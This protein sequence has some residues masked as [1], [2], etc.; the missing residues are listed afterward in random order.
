MT[1]SSNLTFRLNFILLVLA[2][3]L[4]VAGGSLGMVALRMQIESTAKEASALEVEIADLENLDRFLDARMA[5]IHQ[6]K[7]LVQRVAD[8]GLNLRP[9]SPQQFVHVRETLPE[10][11][12]TESSRVADRRYDRRTQPSIYYSSLNNP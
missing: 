11:V 7:E 5:R 3:L 12:F 2:I 10:S 4:V 1:T 8:R 6:P 9:P